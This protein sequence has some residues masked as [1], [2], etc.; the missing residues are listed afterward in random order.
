MLGAP[1]DTY[2]EV[3]EFLIHEAE[4]LDGHRE[5]EWVE[6]CT[7]D[8]IYRMPVRETRERG[9]GDGFDE[10]MFYFDETRGSLELRVRRLETEYAWAEDPPSRT[11]HFVSNIRV[12][13]DGER[14]EIAAK[15]NLLLY[16]SQG[17]E[18][19]N[20]LISAER[21]DVLRRTE[22]GLRL[23]R[24]EILLD[25]SVLTTHNLSIFL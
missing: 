10:Q 19:H 7:D 24:R 8:V 9:A 23:A 21:H 22:G 3:Y 13:D 17:T 20:D 12:S 5:R 11:R 15:S 25:H 1:V 6:L 16:R 2:W 4:L 18:L 14:D